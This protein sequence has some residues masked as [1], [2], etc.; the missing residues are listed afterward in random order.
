MANKEE[1][2]KQLVSEMTEEQVIALASAPI[3]TYKCKCKTNAAKL[4]CPAAL[5]NGRFP[6]DT[7]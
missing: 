5:F 2:I 1:L 4:K 7:K 6:C 3:G